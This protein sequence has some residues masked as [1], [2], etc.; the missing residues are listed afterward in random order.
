MAVELFVLDSQGG[1]GVSDILDSNG[2]GM[3]DPGVV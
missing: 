1:D 2:S 3:L